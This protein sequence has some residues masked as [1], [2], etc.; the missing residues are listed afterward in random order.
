MYK[1]QFGDL[2]SFSIRLYNHQIPVQFYIEQGF[3]LRFEFVKQSRVIYDSCHEKSLESSQNILRYYKS[4]ESFSLVIS[5]TVEMIN[6]LIFFNNLVFVRIL[7]FP[8]YIHFQSAVFHPKF[9]NQLNHKTQQKYCMWSCH[10]P[11]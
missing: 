9:S 3:D 4:N 10:F 2:I 1:K 7:V 5:C 8:A 11:V 6:F